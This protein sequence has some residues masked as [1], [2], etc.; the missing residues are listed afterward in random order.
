M[1]QLFRQLRLILKA[2]GIVVIMAV[3]AEAIDDLSEFD[4]LTI[5]SIAINNNNIYDTSH[6]DYS[7]LLYRTANKLHPRTRHW[8]IRRE[9]L[10][11]EGDRFSSDLAAETERNLRRRLIVYQARVSVRKLPNG[12]VAVDVRTVDQWSLA[13]GIQLSRDGNE[14]KYRVWVEEK[15]FLGLNVLLSAAYMIWEGESNY[16]SS[17]YY[18]QRFLGYAHS[19]QIAY[20]G[21]PLD[22]YAKL[23]F[24]R[25]FYNLSQKFGYTVQVAGTKGRSDVYHDTT[26]VASVRHEGDVAVVTCEY[27][28]GRYNRKIHFIGRHAYKYNRLVDRDPATAESILPGL[29]EDSAYHEDFVAIRFSRPRFVTVERIDSY[30]IVED[31][32][33]GETVQ[34][35]FARAFEPGYVDYIYD[36]VDIQAAVGFYGHSQLITLSCGQRFWDGDGVAL[37]R[38]T[39]LSARYYNNHLPF[40]T[41]AS[42]A[43]YLYDGYCGGDELLVLGGTSGLRGFDRYFRT[44]NRRAIAG[45]EGRFFTGV[46]LFSVKV[47]GAVFAEGGRVWKDGE[48]VRWEGFYSSIGAG[49]RFHVSRAARG[50]ILRFD[51]AHSREAGW[52]FSVGTGQ[53]FGVGAGTFVLTN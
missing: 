46:E 23:A 2:A 26:K 51:V 43:D 4:G 21:D 3:A 27:R 17:R 33:L 39:R 12:H 14:T 19:L 41:I 16:F 29:P 20:S 42:R 37:R 45:V 40:L 24:S 8:I 25:P 38:Q 53:Y 15:N 44:G 18:D 30:G 11:E 7:G 5:D 48:E 28:T 1:A 10:F 34:I 22:G 35:G 31:L 9:L 36:L 13:G 6:P 50:R 47:A 52:Q 32:T 49:L